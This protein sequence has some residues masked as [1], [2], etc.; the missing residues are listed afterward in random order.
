MDELICA[1]KWVVGF[2]ALPVGLAV[3]L[4]V[5]FGVLYVGVYVPLTLTDRALTRWA[6]VA[7]PYACAKVASANALLW[8]LGAALITVLGWFA[9][10]FVQGIFGCD[11]CLPAEMREACLAKTDEE[12]VEQERKDRETWGALQAQDGWCTVEGVP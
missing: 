5:G 8:V 9:P 2:L 3:Y 7:Y 1:A 6:P 4:G 12:L 11:E 10:T